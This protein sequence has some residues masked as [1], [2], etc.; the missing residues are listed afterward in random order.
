M[1]YSNLDYGS[2][3]NGWTNWETWNIALWL[4]NEKYYYDLTLES[5]CFF[6]FV[7]KLIKDGEPLETP[8]GA[9]FFDWKVNIEE[10]DEKIKEL[11][12]ID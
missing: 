5:S 9:K 1:T 2:T 12:D 6:D 10:I 4:D 11:Q 7:L 8:D 3:Y